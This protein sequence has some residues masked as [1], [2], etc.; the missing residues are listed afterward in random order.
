MTVNPNAVPVV[1]QP[2]DGQAPPAGLEE[3]DTGLRRSTS[4]VTLDGEPKLFPGVVSSRSRRRSTKNSQ[5]EDGEGASSRL[6][7]YPTGET[8]SVV[9]E[10]D[11]DDE[12]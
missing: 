3:P 1:Q 12:E 6:R 4:S 8:E 10:K 9:E 11:T 7:R 5:A 2:V